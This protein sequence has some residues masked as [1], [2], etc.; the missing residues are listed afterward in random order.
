M[1]IGWP[2]GVLHLY[3]LICSLCADRSRS[4]FFC[5]ASLPLASAR[6]VGSTFS[7]HCSLLSK[8]PL[9]INLR[10]INNFILRKI[11]GT[12]KIKP[13]AAGSRSEYANH[14]AM[15]PPTD[16]TVSPFVRQTAIST[17]LR[18]SEGPQRTGNCCKIDKGRNLN[19][20]N[21]F[22][23]FRLEGRL[24]RNLE[25]LAFAAKLSPGD[26]FF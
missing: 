9:L 12:L 17:N 1:L 5:S 20:S 2:R 7:S 26:L 23:C 15:L 21:L 22:D 13:V 8:Q 4:L 10:N 3:G 24:E 6:W 11:L 19:R 14:Y 16:I 25:K 18:S